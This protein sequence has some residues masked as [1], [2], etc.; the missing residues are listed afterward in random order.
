MLA[1][2]P[3]ALGWPAMRASAGQTLLRLL[4]VLCAAGGFVAWIA[5]AWKGFSEPDLATPEGEAGGRF[6]AWA[7][8]GTVAMIV[9]GIFLHLAAR[10]EDD[11]PTSSN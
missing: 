4:G 11:R 6:L 1:R 8:V 7:L 9:G 5:L 3:R 2:A 10:A